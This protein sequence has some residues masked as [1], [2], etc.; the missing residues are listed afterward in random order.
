MTELPAPFLCG[1]SFR[2]SFGSFARESDLLRITGQIIAPILR[3]FLVILLHEPFDVLSIR[4]YR[5]KHRLPLFPQGGIRLER[6]LVQQRQTPAVQ[7]DMVEAPQKPKALFFRA[8]NGDAHQRILGKV[9]SSALLSIG[10]MLNKRFAL[11]FAHRAQV[12]I[13]YCRWLMP[14]NH[15]QRRICHGTIKVRAKHGMPLHQPL[16]ALHKSIDINRSPQVEGGPFKIGPSVRMQQTVKQ[17]SLLHRGQRVDV[18][19]LA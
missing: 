10:E 14:V 19:D 7:D 5:G 13:V 3:S 9:K 8:E 11:Y 15:L 18:L 12:V 16:D 2:T 6:F 1:I 17:H 4:G